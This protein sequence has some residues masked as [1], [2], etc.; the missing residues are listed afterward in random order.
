MTTFPDSYYEV[1]DGSEC[2]TC[3]GCG[4]LFL[5]NEVQEEQLRDGTYVEICDFCFEEML[6][7]GLLE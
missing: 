6:D 3:E 2:V 4:H 5:Y 1:E 7:E